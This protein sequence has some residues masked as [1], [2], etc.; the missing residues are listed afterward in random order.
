MINIVTGR[1]EPDVLNRRNA[2][3][4]LMS[5]KLLKTVTPAGGKFRIRPETGVKKA[6]SVEWLF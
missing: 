2:G 1:F 3:V 4:L 6:F 5:A